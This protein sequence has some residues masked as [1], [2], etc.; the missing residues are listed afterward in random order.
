MIALTIFY[1]PA[2]L[3]VMTRVLNRLYTFRGRLAAFGASRRPPW[4]YLLML[5][6]VVLCA[7]KLISTPLRADKAGYRDVSQWLQEHSPAT[8]VIAD[9]DR[10]ICFY[11][12]RTALLYE[13][14]P[15]WRKADFVVLIGRDSSVQAPEG[16][17]LLYSVPV[18]PQDDKKLTVYGTMATPQ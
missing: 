5:G 8:A 15:N 18:G 12:G 13:R 17:K 3:D 11:A 1:L 9:P 16:W 2:G 7:P 4:F 14:Y 10:R 6:G